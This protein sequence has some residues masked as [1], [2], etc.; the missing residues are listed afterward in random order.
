MTAAV[1]KPR[2][3]L[4]TLAASLLCCIGL[5]AAAQDGAQTGLSGS[6]TLGL[7]SVDT[8]G[9]ESKYRE[10]INLDD[11]VRLLDLSLSYRPGEAGAPVD[12][13]DVSASHLG[14][15][16]FESVHVDVRRY[17]AYRLSLD[18][19]R[20]EYFYDDT[21]LP[22]ALASVT[23]STG[24]DFHTFDFER[25]RESAALAITPSPA[26]EV[27][28]GL[29]RQRRTGDS[30]TTLGIQRDQF[31][32]ERP[33]DESSD[34]VKL[35]VRHAWERISVI[36]A[37][38]FGE[39]DNASELFLP[40]AS[41][42]QNTAD[43]AELLF[44]RLDQSYDF[45]SRGRAL[46]V[47]VTPTEAL[48]VRALWRRE[49]VDLEGLGT[50]SSAGTDFAGTPF[51]TDLSGAA[52]VS[53][54]SEVAGLDFGYRVGPRTR[55][56]AA[57]R[58]SRLDQTGRSRFGADRGDGD[59]RV[60]TDGIEI[61]AEHALGRNLI[62]AGGWSGESRDV[63]YAQ[64][65]NAPGVATLEQ[66][67]R[68]GYF[69]RLRYATEG[70]AEISAAIEDNS[71]DDPFTLASPTESR[72]YKASYRQSWDNGLSLA[73]S[74]KRTDVANDRSGWAA[75]TREADIRLAYRTEVFEVSAGLTDVDLDREIDQLVTAGTRQELYAITYSADAGFADVTLRGRLN[76]RIAIG[77]SFRRYENRGSFPLDRD[78]WR[79][80]L[81][82]DMTSEFALAIRYRGIDYVE[83]GFDDY[84]ADLLEL[85][86]RTSW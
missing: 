82:L 72:R 59:W 62:V 29:E 26:T 85:A 19:R 83:D 60:E 44:F 12:Y 67:D 75:D 79:I 2:Y 47:L 36:Y 22:A 21:I 13:I 68:D 53:R 17:G 31:E 15:D 86:V 8:E 84:E 45:D 42:G 1:S 6:V 38:E 78:D 9:A 28:L 39:F 65:L 69:L 61:G 55:L 23:G 43:P 56:T 33:I 3:R 64:S 66:T 32:F 80:F 30:Q 16:P 54:D 27:S 63:E 18:R 4:R 41:P 5:P 70:G 52:D 57:T 58:R 24:G 40:G 46:R 14:G 73:G 25:I 37:E 34:R 10:D 48:D 77:G 51:M 20:S 11:G 50:E 49:D 76:P 74:F 81:E 71:I 7:R 35:G